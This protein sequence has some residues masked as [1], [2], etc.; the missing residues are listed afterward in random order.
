MSDKRN[1]IVLFVGGKMIENKYFYLA[2]L[3][4]NNEHDKTDE[5]RIKVLKEFRK[6]LSV[7]VKEIDKNEIDFYSI[8]AYNYLFF[9]K[10]M[11]ECKN[12]KKIYDYVLDVIS[13]TQGNSTIL[14]VL[15]EMLEGIEELN[16]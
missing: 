16:G 14:V 15:K 7:V 9:V 5:K 13:Y 2:E 3:L 6:R 8:H 12:W 1:N 4:I 11:I 10:K